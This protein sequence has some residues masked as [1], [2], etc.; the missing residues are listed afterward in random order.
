[1]SYTGSTNQRKS[2]RIKIQ[3]AVH[4]DFSSVRYFGFSD[5]ICMNGFFI[6]GAFKQSKGDICKIDIKKSDI[7]SDF[8]VCA[9]ASIV[10]VDDSGIALEFIAMKPKG[11]LFLKKTLLTYATDPSV[12][13][14]EISRQSFFDFSDNLVCK[15]IFRSER[16]KIKKILN[17]L[18]N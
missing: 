1:M 16:N 14:D 2:S 9:I 4:L 8:A 17:V 15:S 18:S 12:L 11:Y 10:R 5:N 7:H 13:N 3:L 6:R